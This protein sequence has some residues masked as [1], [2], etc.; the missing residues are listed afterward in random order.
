MKRRFARLLVPLS[1]AAPTVL[2]L[3]RRPGTRI[4]GTVAGGLLLG[5]GFSN[6][7]ADFDFASMVGTIGW[8]GLASSLGLAMLSLACGAMAWAMTVSAVIPRAQFGQSL[9]IFC[10]SLPLKYLPGS[11]WNHIGKAAKVT[12]P[13]DLARKSGT[14]RRV[15]AGVLSAALDFLMLLWS[16]MIA[17][18]LLGVLRVPRVVS[19]LL[20]YE[21]WIASLIVSG[22]VAIVIPLFSRGLLEGGIGRPAVRFAAR[23]WGAQL[24]QV[25]GW[26]LS[27]AALCYVV[28]ALGSVAQ[29][30]PSLSDSVFALYTGMVAGLAAIFVP[31]GLGVREWVISVAYTGSASTSTAFAAGF[32]FR[33]LVM[34]AELI[35]FLVIT[36]LKR[37]TTGYP[38]GV[39]QTGD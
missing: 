3:M 14:A 20:S 23:I 21:A 26:I 1:V 13:L 5:L 16:G 32:G 28:T 6:S 9:A 36:I 22:V 31:N 4:L 18:L 39:T 11:V 34:L 10:E 27:G 35:A 12:P 30:G 33:V 25:A 7:F 38:L 17:T 2:R 29:P 24:F 8:R 15:G 19:T 37:V